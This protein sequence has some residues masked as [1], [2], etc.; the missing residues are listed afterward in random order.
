MGNATRTPLAIVHLA[1]LF[2]AVY[3]HL[4]PLLFGSKTFSGITFLL[5][6]TESSSEAAYD[7][8]S[9]IPLA[10]LKVMCWRTLYYPYHISVQVI[11]I[12]IWQL[13]KRSTINI[14]VLLSSAELNFLSPHLN[15]DYIIM[16]Y[17]N[18]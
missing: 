6:N 2:M 8:D 16:K 17:K 18:I 7:T 14:Y 11:L 10:H 15:I 1:R 5:P 3:G 4:L 12:Y 13:Y 9:S